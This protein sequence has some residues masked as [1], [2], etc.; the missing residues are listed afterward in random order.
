MT[1]TYGFGCKAIRAGA[2]GANGTMGAALTAVGKVYKDTVSLVGE[3]A[4]LAKHYAENGGK[5]PFLVV[6]TEGGLPLKFT[7]VDISS[8]NLQ[9]WLGG[10]VNVE[11]W[12]MSN[13]SFSQELSVEMDSLNGSTFQ[14][15]RM[16]LY[17]KISWNANRTE[18]YKIE[19]TGEVMEPEDAATPPVKRITTPA[20]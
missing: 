15:A 17:G 7:L 16:L 14:F 11:A 4:T 9:K 12:S 2:I 18:I 20:A 19:V 3:D 8:A 10:T 13:D 5:F 6:V 1:A